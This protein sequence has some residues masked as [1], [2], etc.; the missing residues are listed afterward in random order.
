MYKIMK[1]ALKNVM[2]NKRRSIFTM[3]MIAFG[4]LVTVFISGFLGFISDNLVLSIVEGETGDIQIMAK[5]YKDNQM[6]GS[7]DYV[8][9]NTSKLIAELKKEPE[10][11]STAIR[12]PITGLISNGNQ[13]IYCWGTSIDPAE[14]AK[15]LPRMLKE[16]ASKRYL[17]INATD[18][19]ILGQ[20]LAKKMGATIGSSLF[21]VA[22]DKYGSMS[23]VNL[24][25]TDINKYST[26]AE[27]DSKI[28]T[29]A[30]NAI[31][32]YALDDEVT[33]ICIRIKDRS[34]ATL[35]IPQLKAKYEKK[36]TIDIYPWQEL[37][38]S[39]AQTIGMFNSV[40]FLMLFIMAFI[41]M[42]GVINTILMS[43]FERTSEI[44]TL[45]A[46][47]SSKKRIMVTFMMES[48]WISLIGGIIGVAL[49]A[50]VVV[51]TSI[52]GIPFFAPGTTQAFY[53]KPVLK[54]VMLILSPLCLM[55]VSILA[56]LYPARFAVKLNPVEAIRKV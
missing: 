10:I 37:M 15:T 14:I 47:G 51:I 33:Q 30:S 54:P 11:E 40:Q 42:I 29:T 56:S 32:L 18:G 46:L 2:R 38:G 41:V 8:I 13:A 53:I 23:S 31:L 1:L 28:I 4:I 25:V 39:Y 35:L 43:V 49:G 9:R 52:K 44:G 22:Y 6:S 19:V 26:Q 21:I 3:I 24:T 50:T 55:V 36:Y 5:G 20:G 27:N 45:M 16:G 7:L 17:N 34:K 48:F 12:I